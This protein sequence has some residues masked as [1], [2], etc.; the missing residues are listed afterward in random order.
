MKTTAQ[1][2]LASNASDMKGDSSSAAGTP[3]RQPWHALSA[4]D[5]IR[6][7]GTRPGAL[8][9]LVHAQG[10]PRWLRRDARGAIGSDALGG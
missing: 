3:D 1:H 2:T 6:H 10:M 9:R 7:L 8:D 4:E 5:V